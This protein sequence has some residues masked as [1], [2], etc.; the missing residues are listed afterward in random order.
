MVFTKE[1]FEENRCMSFVMVQKNNR[2]PDL[3]VNDAGYLTSGISGLM[4]HYEI[5]FGLDKYEYHDLGYMLV[6]FG[7]VTVFN[8]LKYS[9]SD[10]V[11]TLNFL[12]EMDDEVMVVSQNIFKNDDELIK[13]TKK[14]KNKKD[15][16]YSDFSL[17]RLN[18][19]ILF[20]YQEGY[21]WDCGKKY[22]KLE[23]HH[24]VP[25][26]LYGSDDIANLIL[27]CG[28]SSGEGAIDCHKNWDDLALEEGLVAFPGFS[29]DIVPRICFRDKT[30]KRQLKP[31]PGNTRN[32]KYRNVSG[33]LAFN[34]RIS[35]R[36]NIKR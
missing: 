4:E 24:K 13:I 35:C 7:R 19:E 16:K 29:M 22:K 26:S 31:E 10:R 6:R 34:N 14:Y 1:N 27:L 21:C 32:R 28:E 17:R 9:R 23:L 8:N 11:A 20:D 36:P 12:E 2:K 5:N 25:R 15:E 30:K 18:K 3:F 33:R